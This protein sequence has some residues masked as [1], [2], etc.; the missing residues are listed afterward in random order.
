LYKPYTYRALQGN[1]HSK[2][3]FQSSRIRKFLSRFLPLLY[4]MRGPTIMFANSSLYNTYIRHCWIPLRSP[5]KYSPWEAMHTC[6]RL[7]HA[8]KQ[9]WN[10]FCWMAF[11]PAVVLLLISSVSSK[12][13][14]FSIS[15]IT[16]NRMW[17]PVNE[18]G[19]PTQ[20]FV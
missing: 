20:L 10:W 6:Q 17:I 4:R 3:K 5:S 16:G 19:V 11:K 14:P 2:A 8:W 15:F 9:F 7:V 12:Y 13:F 18:Q 1:K